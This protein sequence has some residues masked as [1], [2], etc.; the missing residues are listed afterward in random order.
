MKA[1]VKP[2]QE[3]VPV[4]YDGIGDHPSATKRG[5]PEAPVVFSAGAI[6]E[7]IYLDGSMDIYFAPGIYY[8]GPDRI[9]STYIQGSTCIYIQPNPNHLDREVSIR[10]IGSGRDKTILRFTSRAYTKDVTDTWT[11]GIE[12]AVIRSSTG[13]VHEI[14]ISDLTVDSNFA[15]QG[16]AATGNHYGYKLHGIQIRCSQWDLQRLRVIGCGANSDTKGGALQAEAFPINCYS[17]EADTQSIIRHCSVEGFMSTNGGY[18]TMIAVCPF[19]AHAEP[20]PVS[21]YDAAGHNRALKFLS[22]VEDNYIRGEPNC[23]GMGASGTGGPE[24][25]ASHYVC[26]RRN[27][28]ENCSLGFN[29]DTGATYYC[30]YE[31]NTF[32]NVCAIGQLGT[33]TGGTADGKPDP[34]NPT[35]MYNFYIANNIAKLVRQNIFVAPG[36]YVKA[37]G[38]IIRNNSAGIVFRHNSLMTGTPFLRWDGTLEDE[39]Y[40]MICQSSVDPYNL[41]Y[42]GSAGPSVTCGDDWSDP[43]RTLGTTCIERQPAPWDARTPSN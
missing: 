40:R 21:Y 24:F 41:E 34:N 11:N 1:Y 13:Y 19:T 16:T 43:K 5:T 32:I 18:A 10:L 8:V 29:H 7:W 22:V 30:H 42:Y 2:N 15:G 3:N 4:P 12:D 39:Y 26:F 28:V 25:Y 33:P 27:F 35:F 23:N 20:K 37:A 38:L 9:G 17:L 14:E 6:S 31:A 36:D